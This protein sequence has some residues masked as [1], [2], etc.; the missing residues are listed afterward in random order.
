MCWVC[1]N[2][3][4]TH[5][6]LIPKNVFNLT[7]ERNA[8]EMPRAMMSF[9]QGTKSNIFITNSDGEFFS[10]IAGEMINQ[11]ECDGSLKIANGFTNAPSL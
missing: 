10:Y 8:N 4:R 3:K 9:Y 6:T 2:N 11:Y 7:H 1:G 5:W